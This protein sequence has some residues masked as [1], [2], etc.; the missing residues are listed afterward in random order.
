MVGET[1]FEKT[2]NLLMSTKAIINKKLLAINSASSVITKMIQLAVLVWLYQYLLK[3]ISVEE[4]SILPV[5]MAV[6]VFVPLLTMVLTAG[7]ARFIMEAFA[8]GDER[9]ITEIVSTIFPALIVAAIVIFLLGSIFLVYVDNILTIPPGR[10][11]DAR[12]MLGLLLF[13]AVAQLLAS[14]FGTG[15][16]VHQKFVLQNII[17]LGG[18]LLRIAILFILLF[19]VSTRVLWVVVAMVSASLGRLIVQIIISR[20]LVPALKFRKSAIHWASMK[21]L[22]SFNLWSFVRQMAGTVRAGLHPII[23]NKFA[24]PIDITCYHLGTMPYRQI[25]QGMHTIMNPIM[26]VAVIM[27]ATDRS[28]HLRNL[29]FRG[30]RIELWIA[31][32]IVGP[33]MIFSQE[34]VS[35]WVGQQFAVAAA[36]MTI[37][38]MELPLEYGNSMMGSLIYAKGNLAPYVKRIIFLNAV[39]LA[40]VLFMVGAL[41]KGA[42]GIA[43]ATAGTR[44][45]G[46]LLLLWPLGLKIAGAQFSDWL[47]DTL[48]PGLAPFLAASIVWVGFKYLFAPSSWL[49]LGA[50]TAC[51]M[52]CYI[53]I[54]FAFS[55]LPEDRD[56]M[57][58]V[59][60]RLRVKL[61]TLRPG[62]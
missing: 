28:D 14:P 55:M 56:D 17:A 50:G 25:Q 8:K 32:F 35:L 39:D 43:I 5:V 30:G 15:F 1:G 53:V 22:V 16:Y 19:G 34:I 61:A 37:V 18:E 58:T 46:Q 49:S 4:Y 11:A 44:V 24:T 10:V 52:I 57:K 38:L 12:L 6:M 42:L 41:Q 33:F 3:R 26:P 48:I 36:V 51:G 2:E 59:W 20:R 31:M 9:R 45:A 47:K 27:H 40:L 13:S 62:D 23:L 29:Y 7:Q 21:E 54:F 60:D